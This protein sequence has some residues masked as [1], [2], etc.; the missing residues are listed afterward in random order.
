MCLSCLLRLIPN[1]LMPFG[2]PWSHNGLED[3]PPVR[4]LTL[5][6]NSCPWTRA[7]W[8]TCLTPSLTPWPPKKLYT[9]SQRPSRIQVLR[10]KRK[11]T[12]MNS[13]STLTLTPTETKNQAWR[14][15]EFKDKPWTNSIQI[16]LRHR[17]NPTCR[18]SSWKSMSGLL[19]PWS[20]FTCKPTPQVV[21]LFSSQTPPI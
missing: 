9:W 17:S 19:S 18:E 14:E 4:W 2:F 13:T 21:L 16:S 10:G 20:P 1:N 11:W 6:W 7:A 15:P 5:G 8:F 3:R 12:S